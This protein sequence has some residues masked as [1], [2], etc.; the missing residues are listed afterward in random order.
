LW[1]VVAGGTAGRVFSY[2]LLQL[3]TDLD[4]GVCGEDK[5]DLLAL[6]LCGGHD[7]VLL[8]PLQRDGAVHVVAVQPVL[9]L[10]KRLR[11]SLVVQEEA[12]VV[13]RRSD[14]EVR[15]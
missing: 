11:S 13:L 1:Q 6:L 8:P 4:V 5:V 12:N 9:G 10:L 7:G 2:S 14:A 15:Q 3:Q